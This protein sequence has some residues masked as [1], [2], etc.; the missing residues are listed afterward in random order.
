MKPITVMPLLVILLCTVACNSGQCAG[1]NDN[2]DVKAHFH[3]TK[4][5]V[6]ESGMLKKS[7]ADT[8]PESELA[9]IKGEDIESISV[10]KDIITVR[11]KNG[12]SVISKKENYVD[13]SKKTTYSDAEKI[14]TKL[15]E[16]ATYP[17]GPLG[18]MRYLNRT[19]RYPK[20]AEN[21]GIQGTVVVQFI[22]DKEG[23]VSYVESI[24]G[25]TSGGLK[26][27]AERVIKKSGKWIPGKQNGQA[28]TSYKKQPL[29]FMLGSH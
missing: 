21:K 9:K 28:V 29:T 12:D 6:S 14:F 15:E 18:W 11:L 1:D 8:I 10:I 4:F 13:K 27:E 19:F 20:E 5:A 7:E 2:Q 22:V 24:S 23:K 16:E 26:E 3:N 25:P 17:G